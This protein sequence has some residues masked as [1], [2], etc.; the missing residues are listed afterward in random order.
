MYDS[1]SAKEIILQRNTIPQSCLK[2]KKK[3]NA[4]KVAQLGFCVAAHNK[5]S[6]LP[7]K[8]IQFNT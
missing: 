2:L 8:G 4:E 3:K 6:R 5:L 7:W 1:I